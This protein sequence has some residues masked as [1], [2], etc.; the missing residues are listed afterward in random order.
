M[1]ANNSQQ[2]GASTPAP[3]Q[4]QSQSGSAQQMGQTPA[5]QTPAKTIYKDWASI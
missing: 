5:K 3:Q 2:G 4:S 1:S